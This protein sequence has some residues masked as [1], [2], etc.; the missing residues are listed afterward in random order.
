MPT[1]IFRV[2]DKYGRGPWKPGFS[3]SWVEDREDLDNLKAWPLEDVRRIAIEAAKHDLCLG[4]GCKSLEQL[5]RWFTESEF[6][7]LS[8]LGYRAV[9]LKGAIIVR[10][11]ETQCLFARGRPHRYGAREVL[12]YAKRDR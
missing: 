9:A 10:E 11:D 4:S 6:R 2:Q 5:R 7:N 3:E 8:E 12:L 1:T